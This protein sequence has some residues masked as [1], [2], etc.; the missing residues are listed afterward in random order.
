MTNRRKFIKNSVALTAISMLP[1]SKAGAFGGKITANPAGNILPLRLKQGSL[2]GL[3][4]PGGQIDEEQL[5]ETI[6]K[7]EEKL[8]QSRHVNEK[9]QDFT[10]SSNA[11]NSEMLDAGQTYHT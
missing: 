10:V 9:T 1:F 6:E 8:R 3:V 4:T 11:R 2:I 5:D 7:I